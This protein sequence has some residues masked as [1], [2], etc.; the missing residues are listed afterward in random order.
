MALITVPLTTSP[1]QSFMISLPINN[2]NIKLLLD[3][4]YKEA[5]QYWSMTIKDPQTKKEIL[6]NIPLIT[7]GLNAKSA[8]ILQQYQYLELGS[9]F[10]VKTTD[11]NLDYP[12]DKTLGSEF[13]LVW[14]DNYDILNVSTN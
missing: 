6:S 3:L 11:I 1:N 13:V 10:V 4:S 9:A 2:K 14:G 5:C 8:N 7:G 12:D